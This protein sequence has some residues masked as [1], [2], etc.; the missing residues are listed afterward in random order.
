MKSFL[1]SPITVCLVLYAK[2]ECYKEIYIAR[3]ILLSILLTHS[4]KQQ[5]DAK[6]NRLC[7][8]CKPFQL[9]RL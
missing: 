6:F 4:H 1:A 8:C 7:F 2:Q 5:A 9:R 3:E